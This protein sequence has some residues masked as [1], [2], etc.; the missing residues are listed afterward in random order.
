VEGSCCSQARFEKTGP[1]NHSGRPANRSSAE[2]AVISL[3]LRFQRK[4]P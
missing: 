2:A 4:Y 1:I 3:G